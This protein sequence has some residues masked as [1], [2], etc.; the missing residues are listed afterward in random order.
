M[1]L[2]YR[3]VGKAYTYLS[4]WHRCRRLPH[5]HVA[6]RMST[7]PVGNVAR[8]A[9][10]SALR[11]SMSRRPIVSSSVAQQLLGSAKVFKKNIAQMGSSD[12][13]LRSNTRDKNKLS[14]L[15]LNI[16]SHNVRGLVKDQHIEECLA[17]ATKSKA[18][19]TCLQETWMAPAMGRTCLAHGHDA[20]AAQ[21]AHGLGSEPPSQWP[22]AH[23][24]RPHAQEGSL[25]QRPP[26]QLRRVAPD[27]GRP[28]ALAP[29]PH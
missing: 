8:R 6:V 7:G 14:E 27:R 1:T 19:A 28:P 24:L 22:P 26:S 17:F 3:L 11:F 9:A 25:E 12:Q 2:T 15:M 10:R 13:H 23:D 16:I 5:R 20:H 21:T 29:N 4:P 18:W